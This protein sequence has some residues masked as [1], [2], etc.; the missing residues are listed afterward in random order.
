M[1][2]QEVMYLISSKDNLCWYVN[3]I[4]KCSKT[5]EIFATEMDKKD[6]TDV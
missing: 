3:N 4:F 2:K 6:R 1:T 5:G